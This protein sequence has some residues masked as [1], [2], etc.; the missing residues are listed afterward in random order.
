MSHSHI[1]VVDVFGWAQRDCWNR[2]GGWLIICLAAAAAKLLAFAIPSMWYI[3]SKQ[4]RSCESGQGSVLFQSSLPCSMVTLLCTL[5]ANS[6]L[7]FPP[8]VRPSF[9]LRRIRS[10]TLRPLLPIYILHQ[11]FLMEG[12]LTRCQFHLPLRRILRA[13]MAMTFLTMVMEVAR[14]EPAANAKKNSV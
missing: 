11:S 14:R 6:M 1:V 2:E 7:Q 9:S 8:L 13:A 4:S 5:P 10:Q 3:H 12:T